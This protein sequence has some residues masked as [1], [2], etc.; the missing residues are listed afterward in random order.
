M[1]RWSDEGLVTIGPNADE[2][3]VWFATPD[4]DSDDCVWEAINA[5]RVHND[6]VE[7]RAVPALT[8]GVAYGDRIEVVS[9]SEG[10]LVATRILKR[11]EYATFRIWLGTVDDSVLTWRDIAERF[12]RLGCLIDVYSERLIALAALRE[13]STAVMDALTELAGS[14]GIEWE[15]G[16]ATID[17]ST[18]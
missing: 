18:S 1:S 11:G 5:D 15:S 6:V 16:S 13:A 3:E 4:D 7:L 14:S 17:A 2:V 8:Y 12:A 9:S 10:P